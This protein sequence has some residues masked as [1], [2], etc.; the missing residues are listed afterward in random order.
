M[1]ITHQTHY[2]QFEKLYHLEQC[3]SLEISCTVCNTDTSYK[4]I[5]GPSE[6]I[7]FGGIVFPFL[8]LEI[9]EA[10]DENLGQNH[11]TIGRA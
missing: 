9:T 6:F 5:C 2:L 7:V 1:L 11:H 10:A 4:L 8:Y 3:V